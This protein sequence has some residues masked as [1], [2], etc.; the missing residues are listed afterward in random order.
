MKPSLIAAH[1]GLL[2]VWDDLKTLKCVSFQSLRA[3]LELMC[4]DCAAGSWLRSLVRLT[5]SS[6]SKFAAHDMLLGCVPLPDF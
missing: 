2:Y 6:V 4:F 3:L 5:F 1:M